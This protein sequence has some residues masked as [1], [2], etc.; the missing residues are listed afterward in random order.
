MGDNVDLD[1]GSGGATIKTDDDGTA[2]W[3]Y[4][5]MS[6]GPDNT[7]TR[8]TASVG[9]PCVLLAGTAEFGKLAAGTAEIG[10]VK[11]SGTFV[12]QEDGAALTALQL[13]DDIVYT[14][15]GDWTATSSKHAL[16]GGVYQS[17]PGT[18]TDG[19]TGPLRVDVNGHVI[20]SAHAD[21][22]ALADNVS[23]TANIEVDEAGAFKV[24]ASFG[25]CYDGSTWDRLRGDSTNGLL[26]NLGSNN[27]ITAVVTNAGTFAVQADSVIPGVGATNLGKAIDSAVGATDT[28]I[29]LLAKHKENQVHLATADD[30]YDI[31]T[32]DRLGSLHV[33]A[34][35][36]H[37]FD[38]LNATTGWTVLGD[39]TT[40]LATTKK[41]VSGTDA[42]TFDKANG[43]ANTVFAGIQKTLSSVDLG[44]VS[45]HDL[46]QGTF[47]IPTLTDVSYAFL[48]IGTDSSNYN[49]WQLPDTVLTAAVFEVGALSVGDADYTAITGDGWDPSAITYISIGVA[50]DSETDTLAGIVFDEISYHTNQHTS[51]II[52]SEVTSEVSS[53]NIN[54]QRIGGSVTDKGAG[55]ESNG[56]QRIVIATDDVNLSAIKTA[57]EGA[58][59]AG[60]NAIGKLAANSGVDI[61]D[62]DVTSVPRSISGPA[63]PGNS[64]D[65]YTQ[66][67]I[68]LTTGA[69]QVLVS[70]APS[71]QIWVYG[72]T[73]TCGDADGQTVSFQDEDDVALSGIMEFQRY[74]GVAISPSGNFSM[75]IFKLATNK[76]LEIDIT[77]GDVDG[78]LTYAILSV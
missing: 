62:V 42:L 3:Q 29:A 76:D 65:S 77:G 71:K 74:G 36:H 1:A 47:Y 50:F 70:S 55:N 28:G 32:M 66:V 49:E 56:S 54:L 51:A 63:E 75:P 78:W 52:G 4:V 40:N 61:G 19:D 44:S 69:D 35:S 41:H 21:S 60:T 12:I 58:T 14:D 68:N 73:F 5:K 9:L 53:A 13:I 26:V 11:N 15:D 23:N 72:Y 38:T 17:T 7:Q 30:D 34:E 8:V 20:T 57:V 6:Y 37:V 18:I 45:A 43:T 39:D 2:H 48:R 27:D 10:N 31:L 24:N 59:P 64:I 22:I 25:Y 46:L 16:I 67:A 33:N